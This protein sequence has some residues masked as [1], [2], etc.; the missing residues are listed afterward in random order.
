ME[1]IQPLAEICTPAIGFGCWG[2]S[3]AYGPA[4]EKESIATIEAALSNGVRHFDTADVYG[5]GHN[6]SFLGRVLAGRRKDVFLATKFGFVGDEHGQIGVDGRPE[7]VKVACEASLRR[8]G[9]EVIDLYYLHRRDK[10]VE[11]EETVG[12][13][14]DL[15]HEGKVRYL[16]LSEVS[17]ETLRRASIV[18]PITAL[19]SEYSLFTRDPEST[20]IPVCRELGTALV[21]FSPLGRGLLTG[22]VKSRAE[23]SEGDYRREMP[24][25]AEENLARN[26]ALV[27]ALET[28]ALAKN[29]TAAQIALA[30]LLGQGADILPIP[31]MKRRNHLQD[32]L[33]ALNIQ[34]TPDDITQLSTLSEAVRGQRHNSHNL[35]FVE[36][37]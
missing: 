24:R 1:R 4:E 22:K 16:G 37:F 21:A 27:E 11:I 33:G 10:R 2:M 26:C 34:L 32:N 35:K 30:W 18:H 5:G 14:A 28:M 7:R 8:L 25:F 31:G 15:V 12:A 3:D 20:V 23:L 9:T 19:Q 29:G 13:M 6:E 17:A 36:G